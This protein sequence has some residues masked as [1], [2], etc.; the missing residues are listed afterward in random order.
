MLLGGV[1]VERTS[2]GPGPLDVAIHDDPR[3]LV[4]RN[5]YQSY[6]D[7]RNIGLDFIFMAH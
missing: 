7:E 5:I 3:V 4:I 6:I 2:N 1:L